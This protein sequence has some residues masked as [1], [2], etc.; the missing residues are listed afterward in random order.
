MRVCAHYNVS[1]RAFAINVTRKQ[2]RK[3]SQLELIKDNLAIPE[4]KW[5]LDN[6][7]DLLIAREI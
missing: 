6:K 5:S 3:D 4:N 1:M 7:R 2:L